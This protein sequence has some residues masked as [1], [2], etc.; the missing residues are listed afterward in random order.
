MGSGADM[1][2]EMKW[3]ALALGKLTVEQRSE[4][5]KMI[6]AYLT[7][8]WVTLGTSEVQNTDAQRKGWD[9]SIKGN[10][11]ATEIQAERKAALEKAK[12]KREEMRKNYVGHVTLI[13][14]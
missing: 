9:G 7:S 5:Q 10:K 4:L 3:L 1:E 13:K 11:T 8:K 12:A 2:H 14:Q 6:R